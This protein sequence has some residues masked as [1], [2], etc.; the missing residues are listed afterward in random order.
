M[1][2][3]GRLALPTVARPSAR[4]NTR[5]VL[6]LEDIRTRARRRLPR[7][8]FDFVDGGADAEV[9]LRR[10]VEAFERVVLRPRQLVDVSERSLST[11]VLGQPVEMPVLIAPTGMSRVAGPGGDIAGARA[12]ARAGT[13]FV[14][15]TMSSQS[16][17]EVRAGAA[18]E[19]WFQLYLWRDRSLVERLLE[20]ARAA[21]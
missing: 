4:A 11:T 3:R 20:R 5:P 18:A 19:L 16:I 10:N 7:V 17:E 14:L 6:C 13:V 9:T 1:A 2:R 15:S 8:A 12:A 21:S